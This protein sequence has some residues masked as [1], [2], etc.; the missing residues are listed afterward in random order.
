[1]PE[2]FYFSVIEKQV[3]PDASCGGE[4]LPVELVLLKAIRGILSTIKMEIV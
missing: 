1:V 4:L 3:L 2:T